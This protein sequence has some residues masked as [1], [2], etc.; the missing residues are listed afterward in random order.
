MGIAMFEGWVPVVPFRYS[1]SRARGWG[2]IEETGGG[3]LVITSRLV[4]D[5][6]GGSASTALG[7]VYGAEKWRC[8]WR[9]PFHGRQEVDVVVV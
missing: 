5:H 2:T 9:H 3:P 6:L 1:P 8:G 4:L 7:R